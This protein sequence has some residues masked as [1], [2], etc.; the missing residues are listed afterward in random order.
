MQPLNLT[1]DFNSVTGSG[2]RFM[3]NI[4]GKFVYTG[5]RENFDMVKTNLFYLTILS[6]CLGL[7]FYK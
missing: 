4:F 7:Y 5:S 1:I 6:M 2:M 3:V